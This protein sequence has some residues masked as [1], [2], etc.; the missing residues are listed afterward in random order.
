MT[1]AIKTFA[2]RINPKIFVYPALYKKLNEKLR[3]ITIHKLPK[4]TRKNIQTFWGKESKWFLFYHS[5]EN[6]TSKAKTHLYFPDHW[7]IN[8]VDG[9][10]NNWYEA[11]TFENKNFFDLIFHDVYR[12]KAII[13]KCDGVLLDRDYSI[14]TFSEALQLCSKQGE[15]IIKPSTNTSG[16]KGIAFWQNDQSEAELIELLDMRNDIVVQEVVKQ[17]EVLSSIH[18]E[19]INTI[20]IITL[21][22]DG[23]VRVLSSVL[24]MGIGGARVDNASAGGIAVGINQDGRLRRYA[25]ST[26]GIKFDGHPQSGKIEGIEVPG[27][28]RCIDTCK[29]IAPRLSGISKL[30]SWDFAVDNSATPILIESNLNYGVIDLHQMCNGPIFKDEETTRQMIDRFIKRTHKLKG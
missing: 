8:Y 27:Y 14:I 15:V 11:Q 4:E 21:N 22:M 6:G 29:R 19:S 25:F 13:R 20:R 12:P 24:R 10:L 9:N 30:T 18:K 17:H 16:G 1:E 2:K 23:E 5:I 26:N 3:S 7:F 28:N